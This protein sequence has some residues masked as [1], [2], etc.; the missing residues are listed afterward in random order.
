MT[1]RVLYVCSE[2]YPLLKTGGLADVSAGL[3]PALIAAGADVRLLLPAFPSVEAGVTPD[4]EAL[5][6]PAGEADGLGPR[7]ATA[8]GVAP[9]L[10]RGRITASGQPVWLLHAP[11]L[12]GRPGNPYVDEAGRP[13]PD[14]AEQFA[15]LG[16]A[17]AR[18]GTGLDPAWR[19]DVVHGHDWHAGLA[20]AYLHRLGLRG[21]HRPATVFT[22]H[23]LAYQGVF[24]ASLRER[25]GLPGAGPTEVITDLGIM[26]PDAET[27]ELIIDSLEDSGQAEF[28]VDRVRKAIA[29]RTSSASSARWST[30]TS[31]RSWGPWWA[32]RKQRRGRSV[33]VSRV[34][35]W[36]GPARSSRWGR[37]GTM[38]AHHGPLRIRQGQ[39]GGRRKG[40]RRTTGD[41]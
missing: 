20:F 40:P 16:W 27:R 9:W 21:V 36:A 26:E 8:A 10:Q 1:T 39:E 22:I 19:P 3:P 24:P 11:G 30:M 32:R 25:L 35:D 41:L 13:W 18:L 28:V 34:A 2:V 29:A 23:N 5:R 31:S 15:W 6:L 4:G 7:A 37:R 38:Q 17:A 33:M 14:A 12:Y